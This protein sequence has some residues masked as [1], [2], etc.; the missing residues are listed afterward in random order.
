MNE[1]NF[2]KQHLL[3]FSFKGNISEEVL[4]LCQ[5][6]NSYYI[7]SDL[8][9]I[10]N[11]VDELVGKNPKYII[12]LGLYN[13]RDKDKL[14]IESTCNNQ[15]RNDIIGNMFNEYAINNFFK[16]SSYMKKS[17]GIGNS[18]CNYISYRIMNLIQQKKLDSQYTFIHIPQGFDQEIAAEEILSNIKSYV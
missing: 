6:A 1:S 9:F 11:F 14:R 10:D 2:D 7:L 3:I 4:Q 12:G 5:F 18:Y 16:E 17:K 15:F 13:G 8:K